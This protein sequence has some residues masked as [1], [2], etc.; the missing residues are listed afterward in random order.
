[1]RVDLTKP[2][3]TSSF[4]SCEKDTELI[5]K[6]LFF[7]NRPYSDVLKK[8]LVINTEDC[9]DEKSKNAKRY[10]DFI[11]KLSV[12]D[13]REKGYIK[14]EP[15]LRFKEH[16]D[17]KSYI[18]LAFDHFT[19]N[20][21]NPEYRDCTV[22]FDIV[23]HTDYWDIQNYQLRPIKIVGYIDGIL[24]E[25]KLTGIGKF[26]FL[27]CSTLLLDENLSGYTLMYRAVHDVDGDDKIAPKE[28]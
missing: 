13:L 7:D 26:H 12:K 4:L 20:A 19:P 14:L 25:T 3:I 8:L 10:Q 27:G 5:L 22:T 11:D 1:M 24:N 15:K 18:F 28:S 17:V 2:K 9:I 16:E 6:K 21:T 23:C